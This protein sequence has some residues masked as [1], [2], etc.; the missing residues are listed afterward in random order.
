[1]ISSLTNIQ[2]VRFKKGDA[3]I[4]CDYDSINFMEI[5]KVNESNDSMDFCTVY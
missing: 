1:M 5:N 3:F 4:Q 2:S